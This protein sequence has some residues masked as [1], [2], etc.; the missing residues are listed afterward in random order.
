MSVSVFI[1]HPRR[2]EAIANG[3]LIDV[4]ACA[5]DD[6][7]VLPTAITKRTWETAIEPKGGF[8]EETYKVQ[9]TRKVRL[10]LLT[11]AD[12]IEKRWD[13]KTTRSVF[14]FQPDSDPLDVIIVATTDNDGKPAITIGLPEEFNHSSRVT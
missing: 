9:V 11:A 10:L 14:T 2:A 3:E 1:R 8:S 4:S 7:S 12:E 13:E 5:R 6:P